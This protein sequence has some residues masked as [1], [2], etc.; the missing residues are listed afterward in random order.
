M[1]WDANNTNPADEMI[2]TVTH[3]DIVKKTDQA[4]EIK[5]HIHQREKLGGVYIHAIALSAKTFRLE[6]P[7][8]LD[9]ATI[10]EIC[11]RDVHVQQGLLSEKEYVVVIQLKDYLSLLVT[12]ATASKT[13]KEVNQQFISDSGSRI[14]SLLSAHP[15]PCSG[16]SPDQTQSSS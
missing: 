1:R 6:M 13:A 2:T 9:D 3:T 11:A 14:V 5:E 12:A 10:S 7:T 8:N 15:A 16:I 4:L